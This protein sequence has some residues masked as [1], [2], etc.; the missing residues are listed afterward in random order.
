M[1]DTA[2]IEPGQP[3]TWWLQYGPIRAGWEIEKEQMLDIEHKVERHTVAIE[4]SDVV[5]EV[6]VAAWAD[7]VGHAA[8]VDPWLHSVR[9]RHAQVVADT[10][11]G[12]RNHFMIIGRGIGNHRVA[13]H[14]GHGL[15][16]HPQITY[17]PSV[18]GRSLR[19]TATLDAAICVY[20]VQIIVR[21]AHPLARS[22][23]LQ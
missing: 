23:E 1:R 2:A 11:F 17:L 5:A 14:R 7:G 8:A 21:P 20:R 18:K 19:R 3:A 13:S 10:H 22:S 6:E 16:D 15:L 9:S 4:L 12:R